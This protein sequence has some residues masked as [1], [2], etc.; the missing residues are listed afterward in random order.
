ME[1]AI[2]NEWLC[3]FLAQ[4]WALLGRND[5]ALRALR[6]AA[7]LGFINYPSLVAPDGPLAG[8]RGTPA[9]D[10]L[11]AEVEPRWKAVVEWHRGLGEEGRTL[12]A[13]LRGGR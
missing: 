7:R 10:A 4:G 13:H 6:T 11:L 2:S 3:L 5:D 8:L 1:R 12:T 9:F